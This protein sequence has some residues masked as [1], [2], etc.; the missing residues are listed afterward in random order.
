MSSPDAPDAPTLRH[1]VHIRLD[2]ALDDAA[3]ASLEDDLHALVAAHPH[4]VSARLDRDL[5]RRP[6]APVSATWMASF[7]FGS[8]ADFEDYLASPLHKDFLSTHQPSMDF[9][10][11][12]QFAI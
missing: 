9:I 1:V 7:D 5:G 12:I 4:A 2:P 10:T 8:M 6:H 11:A 3:R